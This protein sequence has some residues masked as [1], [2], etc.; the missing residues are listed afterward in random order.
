MARI[1]CTAAVSQPR[2]APPSQTVSDERGES[3]RAEIGRQE[4]LDSKRI[5]WVHKSMEL[6]LLIE[7]VKNELAGAVAA[8]TM[9]ELALLKSEY[10]E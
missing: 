10:D 3:L 8:A 7:E 5:E 1:Y 6:V 4:G 9:D 2:S